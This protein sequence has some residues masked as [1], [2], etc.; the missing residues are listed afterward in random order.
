MESRT[1]RRSGR[2]TS[3]LATG[4]CSL[5]L[6]AA[7]VAAIEG[8]PAASAAGIEGPPL[9]RQH[10]IE[11]PPATHSA[12]SIEGPPATHSAVS[13][14]GP[15]SSR[16]IEGPPDRGDA[17]EG[18]PQRIIIA[19]AKEEDVSESD[20]RAAVQDVARR[21]GVELE[22][23][24]QI[25]TGGE[26]FKLRGMR[27]GSSDLTELIKELN[28]VPRVR[29][30]EEDRLMHPLMTPNDSQY[31][32]QWHYY[33]AT[34]GLDAPAAWD[35]TSGSGSR[36]AVIDTGYRPH[37]DLVANIVGGYDFISDTTIANDG[38]GRDSDAKDP[39]DWY[40]SGQ[41][42][43]GSGSSNS[44]WHGTHVAGTIAALT[45]NST[46]VAGVAF[47]AKVVPLR[48][49]GRCG[50]Y[51]SDIADA[52]IWGSGGSVS[53]V[54]ANSY[55][56]KVLSLSLGGSGSCDNTT[57]TAINTARSRGA[58]MIVAA[59]NS[60]TDASSASPANCSGVIAIAAT[61]RSGG[62]AYY[63]N[64]G[65]LVDVAAPGGDTRSS[66]SNGILSTLNAG[67]TT[68]GADS[69]AWYQ[70]TSM[71]TPHVSAVAALMFAVN[72][73][74]TP[75][76]VESMLKSTARPFPA[77][78]SGCGAGI[79][80]AA[81]A[82]AAAQGGG[83]TPPPPATGSL[84]N[85]VAVTGLSGSTGTELRYTL[86]VPA[87]SSN[88]AISISGGS[89]DADL[90]VK[91]GS[92][93]STSSYDCRPYRTGNAETCN[94]A[95]PQTGTYYVMVRGYSSFSGVS[96][97]GSF[98]AGAGSVG[99]CASGYTAYTGSLSSGAS[100]YAP[101]SSGYTA[102]AA[103]MHSGRLTGPSSADFDLYL[104]YLSGSSWRTAKSSTGS[105][106]TESVDYSGA[107]G[108]TYRWR[109]YAYNGSGS[110][111]LCMKKP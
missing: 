73:S 45:N 57:Q 8:P 102:S 110:Y 21:Y 52:I 74:L 97:V 17:I 76:N 43:A 3:A 7:A 41:C 104:Q 84:S 47:G 39:G 92:A 26:V 89:G 81:A 79:V 16:K 101:G 64:Y 63:S 50:G 78:C 15:P 37:A 55:P 98:A 66:A 19:F 54:P 9:Q 24:R 96:L 31:A 44:S 53:G 42:G 91:F 14:E 18:P 6:S 65:S 10:N 62:R 94:F 68:P 69:Y 30:A 27:L 12:V 28:R 49:L 82:V 40:T 67:T 4:F 25:A 36:I 107:S 93:P 23:L 46:G 71:A 88:L 59:G 111:Q 48:V 60:N 100:A 70:G 85:G 38:N 99:S 83:G 56:A 95:T 33:E 86:V 20:A 22:R 105:S 34:G 80:D 32:S 106:S 5:V 51:T 109:I 75:D 72:G 2:W 35:V 108:T 1:S 87:N 90:Y 103:G 11:G 77:S 13:I 61:N 29:Y 58:V